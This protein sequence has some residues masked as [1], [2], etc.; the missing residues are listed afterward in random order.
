MHGYLPDL[1]EMNSTFLIAGPG[2]LAGRSLGSIDMRDNCA[3]AGRHPRSSPVAGRRSLAPVRVLTQIFAHGV[4]ISDAE[5]RRDM[6]LLKKDTPR[7]FY[8]PT[9]IS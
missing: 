9:Y 5:A 4:P 8:D 1:A 2:I 3:D 7:A 6:G